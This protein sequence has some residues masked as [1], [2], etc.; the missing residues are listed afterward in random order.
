MKKDNN[1]IIA[2]EN[3]VK[4]YKL[5]D[6]HS[7][8][9]KEVF[10]PFR[11][12]YYHQ[13]NALNKVSLEI[14]KGE[15]IGIIGRNGSGKSTL[16]QIICGVLQPTSGNASV[17]GKVSALLELGAGFNPEFTG[18]QNIYI[19][20]AIFGMTDKEI[21]AC[22]SDIIDF[23]DIGEFIDQPV[24]TY[25]SGMYVRLAFAVAV[26]VKPDILVVDEALSVGDTQFQSKCFAK[27][28]EF[29]EKNVTILFVTHA[30]DLITRYCTNA[31]LLEE[32][33][34]YVSG[35]PKA[36]VDEYNRLIVGSSKKSRT[37]NSNNK[38]SDEIK[39]GLQWSHL[40]TTNPEEN[41]YGNGKAKIIEAGIF[42]MNGDHV[43]KLLSSENYS[44]KMK[45]KFNERIHQPI[46]GYT[47]KDVKGF[48]ISG[49]NTLYKEVDTGIIDKGEI[50]LISFV[51]KMLL[52]PGGYLISFGCAG[53]ESGKYVVYERR[54]D[55]MT[56]EVVAKQGTVGIFDMDSKISTRK[57]T[58]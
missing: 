55:F 22:F 56:F 39:S 58:L 11:K 7:D 36:V 33:A 2:L 35:N 12:K 19:N 25:S 41:R 34:V 43:Q 54:Y 16:L 27:F 46:F 10:H 28:K 3:I 14:K 57:L 24:K 13:F 9:V 32:G 52:N 40:F 47:V 23:A 26:N 49:S 20:G 37:N 38:K 29:Q 15:T 8:R 44:F 42:T 5:Y 17:N 48:D 45:V 53:F 4:T 18:R 21:D 1:N 30:L 50:V 51:Q 6:N 31:C